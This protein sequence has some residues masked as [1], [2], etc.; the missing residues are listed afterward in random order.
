MGSTDP[1]SRDEGGGGIVSP[2]AITLE[3]RRAFIIKVRFVRKAEIGDD[4]RSRR[5]L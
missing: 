3:D 1:G 2:T 5:I 4:R